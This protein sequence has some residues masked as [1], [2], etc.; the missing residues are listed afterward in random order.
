MI[1][2][3]YIK[4]KNYSHKHFLEKK[5]EGIKELKSYKYLECDETRIKKYLII[6]V[7]K[8]AKLIEKIES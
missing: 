8:K 3:K 2:L 7:G 5:E 1:K 4:E 6:F